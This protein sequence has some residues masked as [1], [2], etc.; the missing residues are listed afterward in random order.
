MGCPDRRESTVSL[1]LGD[2]RYV[3]EILLQCGWRDA[4]RKWLCR[5]NRMVLWQ[6]SWALGVLSLGP[7][8]IF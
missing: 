3:L 5:S 7:S 4:P 8:L 2:E 6:Q 1:T